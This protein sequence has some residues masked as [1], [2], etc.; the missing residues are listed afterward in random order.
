MN[1]TKMHDEN[2]LLP[3]KRDFM[4]K[5]Y[6]ATKNSAATSLTKQIKYKKNCAP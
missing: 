2:T 1:V 4:S 6:K 3:Q 5:T